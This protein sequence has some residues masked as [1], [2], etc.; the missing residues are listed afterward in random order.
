M[1]A[2]VLLLLST[3]ILLVLAYHRVPE[4][5]AFTVYRLGA[6]RR[7]LAPGV[8]WIVPLVESV[9]HKMSLT[10]RAVHFPAVQ[11][12]REDTAL[13]VG[14]SLWFQ[15]ID[16]ALAD[17]RADHLDDFVLE[18][19]HAALDD[20]APWLATLEPGEFNAA[21][22]TAMNQRLRPHGLLITRCELDRAASM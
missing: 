12:S 8:H 7:T 16:P 15:V 20:L 4:G 9:A 17:P 18:S 11:L 21:V 13:R 6:Y 19:T 5:Q 22:K 10:G 1:S 2:S 3:G 14:G